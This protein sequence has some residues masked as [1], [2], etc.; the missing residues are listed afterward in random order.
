MKIV[1]S[2]DSF[3]GSIS[4]MDAA[5]TL[6]EAILA[7]FPEDKVEIFPLADGGEGTVDAMTQGLDG[8]IIGLVVTG[9]LGEKVV[10]RYGYL[11]ETKMA[12]MEMADA[13][14][15]PMVPVDKRN[16]LNTTTY[17]LGE[18]IIAAMEKGCREFIIGIGGSA[19]NDCGLGMLEALGY[20]FL[21][22]DGTEAGCFGRDLA[23][24]ATIDASQAHPLLAE[25][26]FHIACDVNNPL[27]GPKGCSHIYG[28]QKGAT[29]EIVETMDGYISRFADIAEKTL[30][31]QAKEMPGAGAAGGLGFAFSVFLGGVL[32]PGVDLILEAMGIGEHLGDADVLI[33][34]EGR[35]DQQTA[36][37]KA[38]AG[39]AQLA[40][41]SNPKCITVALCGCAT[42]DAYLVNDHGIDAY[43]PILHNA[44]S[45]EEAMKEGNTKENLTLTVQQVMNLLHR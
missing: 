36:M 22:A 16:P 34:G 19:T 18:L 15:L 39:V 42:N 11:P 30:G 1:I 41:K 26:E 40:K 35:M 23:D 5:R 6:Q 31:R 43:F 33:T 20:R 2:I 25:C 29:P 17:G 4:S 37:G 9:P 8:E 45:V 44:V 32:T 3:K 21:K 28:P 24:I 7:K 14:G 13:S 12:V 27:C 10:S 38:P